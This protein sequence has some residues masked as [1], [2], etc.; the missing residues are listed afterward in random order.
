MSIHFLS[1]ETEIPDQIGRDGFRVQGP[2]PPI[3]ALLPVHTVTACALSR[4]S[5]LLLNLTNAL[6]HWSQAL[7]VHTTNG[8]RDCGAWDVEAVPLHSASSFP[9]CL[10]NG[11]DF[12]QHYGFFQNLLNR[13]LCTWCTAVSGSFGGWLCMGHADFGSA[14]EECVLICLSC[15]LWLYQFLAVLGCWP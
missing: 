5:L 8:S 9:S 13:A 1:S 12:H 2:S 10:S 15:L 3:Q 11:C 4:S 6:P 7:R 14:R